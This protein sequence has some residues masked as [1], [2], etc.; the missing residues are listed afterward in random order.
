M[1][2]FISSVITIPLLL[3]IISILKHKKI[4]TEIRR[5]ADNPDFIE[6][7]HG[8]TE[9]E[10]SGPENGDP[11]ILV[12]GFSVPFFCWDH[13]CSVLAGQGHRVLRYNHYGRGLSD[14]AGTRYDA[15]LFEGQ[16]DEI[17]E[18]LGIRTPFTLVGLSMGGAV[19]VYYTNRHP[20]KVKQVALIS[21]AG[22]PVKINPAMKLLRM[23]LIG[24]FIFTVFGDAF[25]KSRNITNLIS[26]ENHPEYQ[27]KFINCLKYRGRTQALLSTFRNMPFNNMGEEYENLPSD[28]PV[29]LMWGR[30]DAVIPF[31]N[32]ELVRRAIKQTEFYPVENTGHNSQYEAPDIILG[33]LL[34]FLA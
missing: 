22:F 13:I 21:P 6:L 32:N 24:D 7:T 30:E 28:I 27:K 4:N 29:L 20:E 15:A 33:H 9:Y 31:L 34:K 16:L 23:P 19:S 5:A 3:Y 14:H 17:S 25:L 1:M 12:S 26:F 2:V 18:K 11:V 10:L 8:Y